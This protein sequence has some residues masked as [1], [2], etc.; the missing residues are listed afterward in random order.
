[1][2][3][4]DYGV[5]LVRKKS[6]LITDS[7]LDGVGC[8]IVGKMFF[9]APWSEEELVVKYRTIY[10][11]KELIKQLVDDKQVED[12]EMIYVTDLSVDEEIYSYIVKH[13]NPM[14]FRFIDHH[15]NSLEFDKY[16]YCYVSDKRMMFVHYKQEHL[17][18]GEYKDRLASATR[19]FYE[20][21]YSME[22]RKI[23]FSEPNDQAFMFFIEMVSRYDTW[24]WTNIK[25]FTEDGFKDVPKQLNDLYYFYGREIFISKIMFKF[26]LINPS[27]SLINFLDDE[28]EVLCALEKQNDREIKKRMKQVA[29]TTMFGFQFAIVFSA[30]NSNISEFG[31]AFL[32]EHPEVD[33]LLQIDVANKSCQLRTH[34]YNNIN[35]AEFA[36]CYGGGGH[37][38]AS[39]FPVRED[40][41][42]DLYDRVLSA[43]I[44]KPINKV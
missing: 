34:Q 29:Y 41:F 20:Y 7:D 28:R 15:Q 44:E 26:G 19:L 18:G 13:S 1:M 23:M 12:Y 2:A 32:D 4:E 25:R 33:I 24:E 35:V 21:L 38:K 40:M 22:K 16:P 6:L 9:H 37:I 10:S 8:A 5:P 14:R 17:G 27:V 42:D 43:F 3:N 30:G 39:G 36:R 31:K 11:Y